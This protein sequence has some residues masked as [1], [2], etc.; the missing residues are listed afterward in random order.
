MEKKESIALMLRPKY[1]NDLDLIEKLL[2]C[3]S[4]MQEAPLRGFELTV[5]KYYIKY[6]Y[7]K[8][9]KSYIMEDEKKKS[10]DIRTADVHLRRNGY[11][12]HG[13]I[14]MRKSS[15]SDDMEGIRKNFIIQKKNIYV[16]NFIK[17][18]I[19]KPKPQ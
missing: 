11:V 5:L 6:G 3:Y 17:E 2:K 12:L 18:T 13:E 4:I 16:L 10:G 15:L 14:N 19:E 1:S 8:E 9:A 7:G